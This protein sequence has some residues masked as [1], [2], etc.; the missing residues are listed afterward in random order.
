MGK[1]WFGI[2]QNIALG[3]IVDY[4]LTV[5][6]ETGTFEG[7]TAAW[8]AE[9]FTQVITIEVNP[10]WHQYASDKYDAFDNVRFVLGDSRTELPKA[11]EYLNRRALVWLDAHWTR[12]VLGQQMDCPI[13]QELEALAKCNHKHVI[14]IDD[15]HFWQGEIPA[16]GTPEDWVQLD[17][18]QKI[19]PGYTWEI[20]DDVV[21]CKPVEVY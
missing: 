5:F 10:R 16:G 9:N 2:P 8:A 1:I 15:A 17:E 21:I 14:M 12:N 4:G 11:L 7:T 3:L 6:V 18:M 13:R 19:L 20:K